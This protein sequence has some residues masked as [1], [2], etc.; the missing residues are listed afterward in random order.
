MGTISPTNKDNI[1]SHVSRVYVSTATSKAGTPYSR[2]HVIF[3][4]PDG[5]SYEYTSFLNN[6]QKALIELTQ[7]ITQGL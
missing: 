2:L 6:E 1:I 5:K 4:M 3:L 7:P